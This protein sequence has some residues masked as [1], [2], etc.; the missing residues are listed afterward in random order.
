MFKKLKD[1][2]E[3]EFKQAPLKFPVSVQQL[4]QVISPSPSVNS[5]AENNASSSLSYPTDMPNVSTDFFSIGGDDDSQDGVAKMPLTLQN[6]DLTATSPSNM[7]H[8]MSRSRRSSLS[9]V[10]SEASSLFPIYESGLNQN[11]LQSDL[12]S[13]MEDGMSGQIDRVSKEQLYQTFK[14]VLNRYNKYKGR[15]TDL[16]KHYKELQHENFK[17]KNVLQESQDKALRRMAELRE[18]CQLEQKAKAHLEES[19]RNDVEER[20]HIIDTLKTKISLL[21]SGE[22][23][24][25]LIDFGS[26]QEG[27]S[28]GDTHST[29]LNHLKSQNEDLQK[30]IE[31]LKKI[32]ET[33]CH[34]IHRYDTTIN[35]AT[36]DV[37]SDNLKQKMSELKTEIQKM[38]TEN[39]S[40]SHLLSRNIMTESTGENNL[41]TDLSSLEPSQEDA[42]REKDEK[43]KKIDKLNNLLLKCKEK[44]NALN[45]E[46]KA[47]DLIIENNNKIIKDLKEEMQN[48]K[49]REQENALSM[50]ENKKAIHEELDAKEKQIK[51]LTKELKTKENEFIK[52]KEETIKTYENKI[53]DLTADFNKEIK[54]KTE[55]NQLLLQ[56]LKAKEIVSGSLDKMKNVEDSFANIMEFVKSRSAT[57][58]VFAN[59]KT[60]EIESAYQKLEERFATAKKNI[61]E[62]VQ[63][64][65]SPRKAIQEPEI[66]K[67][68]TEDLQ[69][70]FKSPTLEGTENFHVIEKLKSDVQNLSKKI[71]ILEAEVEEGRKRIQVEK[72]EG[73]KWK[74]LYDSMVKERNVLQK[75][76]E[77]KLNKNTE[78]GKALTDRNEQIK[79]VETE[80]ELLQRASNEKIE[81]ESKLREYMEKYT[82]LEEENRTL[83][84]DLMAKCDKLLKD[85]NES[86]EKVKSLEE[87]GKAKT[88]ELEIAKRKHSGE[89]KKKSKEIQELKK[90]WENLKADTNVNQ[91][92]F[93]EELEKLKSESEGLRTAAAES[94]ATKMELKKRDE[95]MK[96]LKK[97]MKE[98]EA[99][100]KKELEALEGVRKER[101]Q[102]K[103]VNERLKNELEALRG[104]LKGELKEKEEKSIL[105]DKLTQECNLLLAEI[106]NLK[107]THSS[108][109]KKLE[110][111]LKALRERSAIQKDTVEKLESDLADCKREFTKKTQEMEEL[112]KK[113]QLLTEENENLKQKQTEDRSLLSESTSDI[114]KIR[115]E[116][117]ESE[118]TR[119][120]MNE[121]VFKLTN[122]MNEAYGELQLKKSELESLR[123]SLMALQEN[124]KEKEKS[125]EEE[126]A[127]L[128]SDN[129]NKLNVLKNEIKFI[130]TKHEEDIGNFEENLNSEMKEANE[131]MEIAEKTSAELLDK[132]EK[133][134]NERD[135]LRAAE[136][137]KNLKITELQ[138]CMM[139]L[140]TE[141][142]DRFNDNEKKEEAS[143]QKHSDEIRDI[144][145]QYDKEI[146]ERDEEIEALKLKLEG[147]E[148]AE[149]ITKKHGEEIR[150]IV[151]QYDTEIAQRDDE[152]ELLKSKFSDHEATLEQLHSTKEELKSVKVE[153]IKK[154]NLLRQKETEISP[155]GKDSGHGSAPTEAETE[156]KL[157]TLKLEFEQLLEAEKANLTEALQTEKEEAVAVER[158]IWQKKLAEVTEANRKL[159]ENRQS[160][161]GSAEQNGRKLADGMLEEIELEPAFKATFNSSLETGTSATDILEKQLI[162]Q[163]E[164]MKELKKQ[165]KKEI[166]EL[167][168]MSS[169]RKSWMNSSDNQDWYYTSGGLENDTEHEYLKNILYEY[170]MGKEQLV[171]AKVLSA[172]V[173]FNDEQTHNVLEKEQQRQTLFGQLG[174]L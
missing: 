78:L 96:K 137:E 23:N 50:A 15:Y 162:Q 130:N 135:E 150:Q 58:E 2:I 60:S 90:E 57:F 146:A 167:K 88:Q 174:L 42:N 32:K 44:I 128:V 154:D 147:M 9:S 80:K 59:D 49:T 52:E 170:M 158:E 141:L 46:M 173:K 165:Y 138:N 67:Q 21:S 8:G 68:K 75:E 35:E 116:L 83:Q 47:K 92:K 120:E 101:T 70:A 87:E 125:F 95:E 18:Q 93:T 24:M 166:M 16:L 94:T 91:Q 7:T 145:M 108:T 114:E 140:K 12:E 61:T 43:D 171:L 117:E 161:T 81:T 105:V 39:E 107:K 54:T 25:Q 97:E 98:M 127:R 153:L 6:V 149:D 64:Q 157:Q 156:M 56:D 5:L 100:T 38:K 26:N 76:I 99:K 55:Q 159:L 14:K 151:L 10:T 28:E 172:I 53:R 86:K 36:E 74:E 72:N 143:A 84:N 169:K 104:N 40:L 155:E 48:V 73:E 45:A 124:L 27:N 168:K 119:Q 3:E 164:E 123:T 77:E 112:M 109:E 79:R 66:L 13:E 106:E 33:A 69:W 85:L 113:S 41:L 142:D 163:A 118:K 29:E 63:I 148:D 37:R 139:A 126:K 1:K 136:E 20:D 4:A 115:A 144:V 152:I 134:T 132:L 131:K 111:E 71:E 82:K 129:E 19:L 22:E 160:N 121:K 62:L 133:I 122:D 65:H 102:E 110:N 103:E 51:A 17:T 31:K 89:E 30:E 34:L 11:F